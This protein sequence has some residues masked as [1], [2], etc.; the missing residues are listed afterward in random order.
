ML[1][2]NIA[3]AVALATALLGP[4]AAASPG[5][6]HAAAESPEA[7]AIQTLGRIIRDNNHFVQAHSHGFFDRFREGQHP[8]VTLVGC[9]DSRFQ[10]NDFYADP[11]GE[12][13]VIRNIGNQLDTT[14][15]SVEY[16]V[17]HLHTP[18]LLIV[19][20]VGCSAVRAAMGDY[21][22]ESVTV[23]RE[24]DGLHLSI[25]KTRA[26]GTFDERWLRNVVGNVHQQVE[27]A[28]HEYALEIKAGKLFVVG[29]VYDF[30]ND[31]GAGPGHF[32]VVNVNGE[33]DPERLAQLPLMRRA[34]APPGVCSRC[35]K[36]APRRG[37]GH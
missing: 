27:D 20:H 31:M 13:F 4:A 18:L 5:G 26:E 7:L 21:G 23:R 6:N 3:R 30:R 33:R 28:R 15:G 8:R 12:L 9:A 11:D 37:G 32:L 2:R 17:R 19:G 34:E 16:G 35:H 25:F 36:K 10:T 24:L 29:A 14:S 22:G 1:Q